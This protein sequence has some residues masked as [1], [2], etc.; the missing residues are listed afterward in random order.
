[1]RQRRKDM[2]AILF[3]VTTLYIVITW[4]IV[5]RFRHPE[6]TETQL[7]LSFWDAMLWR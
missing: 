6:L 5:H 1:M 4:A 7:F 3:G 2:L